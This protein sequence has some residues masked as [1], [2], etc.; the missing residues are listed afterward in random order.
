VTLNPA[1]L[2]TKGYTVPGKA[3]GGIS[4]LFPGSLWSESVGEIGESVVLLKRQRE[5]VLLTIRRG[6]AQ[7]SN[8]VVNP[9][10]DSNFGYSR[11]RARETA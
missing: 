11:S 5:S 4:G 10:P 1:V 6:V 7:A 2:R 3:G 8:M 9:Y